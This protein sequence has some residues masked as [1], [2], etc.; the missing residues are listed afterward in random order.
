[1]YYDRHNRQQ[2]G[3]NLQYKFIRNPTGGVLVET[4]RRHDKSELRYTST[5]HRA[6]NVTLQRMDG[7][8]ILNSAI[9][10]S[11]NK[12]PTS[13]FG[14]TNLKT[15]NVSYNVTPRQ[16]HVTTVVEN[17]YVLHILSVCSLSHP[18]RQAHVQ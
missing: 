13:I 11:R 9:K 7:A 10:K 3:T 8:N 14:I 17:Q 12:K 16:V 15:E 6:R 2:F 5:A 1:M 4:S 18:S